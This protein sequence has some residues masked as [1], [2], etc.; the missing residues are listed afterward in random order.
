MSAI[1]I[2]RET[3]HP[4]PEVNAILELDERLRKIEGIPILHQ[5]EDGEC[6]HEN[7]AEMAERY[8]AERA[9]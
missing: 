8:A 4:S 9:K 7:I 6:D 2:L 1:D 3:C 5:M